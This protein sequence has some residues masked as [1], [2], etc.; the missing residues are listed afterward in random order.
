MKKVLLALLC[1]ILAWNTTL[2]ENDETVGDFVVYLVSGSSCGIKN[3]TGS[4][5]NL[6]IPS[7]IN[8]NER[9]YS[10]AE[11]GEKGMCD[12][13]IESITMP[14]VIDI[15]AESFQNCKNLK[16]VDAPNC[17]TIDN[18]AF[19]NCT[20]LHDLLLPRCTWMKTFA[21][22][23]VCSIP[24][25]VVPN[26]I[27]VDDYVFYQDGWSDKEYFDGDFAFQ[28]KYYFTGYSY[29]IGAEITRY[30]PREERSNI[31]IPNTLTADGGDVYDVINIKSGLFSHSNL[32]K[33]KLPNNLVKIDDELFNGCKNLQ[34]IEIPASVY[35]IGRGAFYECSA[36]SEVVIPE[37]SEWRIGD[38][39]IFRGCSSIKELYLPRK[40]K[41]M[42]GQIITGCNV[43]KLFIP[44]DS[45]MER[46]EGQAI[47]ATT[48]RSIYVPSKVTNL[49]V[50]AMNGAGLRNITFASEINLEEIQDVAIAGNLIATLD[51]PSSVKILGESAIADNQ[52][53]FTLNIPADSK[54]EIIKQKA[55]FN[56]PKLESVTF[57]ATLK[58]IEENALNFIG[59]NETCANS[60]LA[61]LS[62]DVSG[63]S[64]NAFGDRTQQ[65]V[66]AKVPE[67]AV[68]AYRALWPNITYITTDV[69]EIIINNGADA[70]VPVNNEITL[71]A[72]VLPAEALDKVTWSSSD[73]SVAKVDQNGI[74]TGIAEGDV[75]ITATA[76]DGSNV[77]GTCNVHV[78]YVYMTEIH[79]DR[80]TYDLRK[81][82]KYQLKITT[83]PEN[84][85]NRNYTISSSDPAI[86]SVSN[87]NV[88][89]AVKRGT[90]TITALSEDGH[91]TAT[92]TVVV[93]DF[94]AALWT[95]QDENNNGFVSFKDK[96]TGLYMTNGDWAS[97][98]DQP[99]SMKSSEWVIKRADN[100]EVVTSV[101]EGVIYRVSSR[102]S[103]YKMSIDGTG[104]RLIPADWNDWREDVTFVSAGGNDYYI[105]VND[106]LIQQECE[107]YRNLETY[108]GNESDDTWEYELKNL[109]S[110]P[111]LLSVALK[112]YK[113][114]ELSV[115]LPSSLTVGVE[116]YPV[117]TIGRELFSRT[118]ELRRIKKVTIPSSIKYI[119]YHAFADT[120]LQT[121]EIES[122]SQLE[123]IGD[124][125]FW[126]SQITS[127][128][129]PATVRTI[130]TR[131][132]GA[133]RQLQ[134]VTI[135][136]SAPVTSIGD[137]AFWDDNALTTF[138]LP[139]AVKT[140]GRE[141]FVDCDNLQTFILSDN[142]QLEVLGTYALAHNGKFVGINI[143][144]TLKV[145]GDFAFEDCPAAT[146]SN[147]SAGSQLQS[148]GINAF[149]NTKLADFYVPSTV[150]SISS[151]AFNE[152]YALVH[153][154]ADEPVA[155][156]STDLLGENAYAVVAKKNLE[157]Y[158]HADMW[159]AFKSQILSEEDYVQDVTIAAL[160]GESAL[161]NMIGNDNMRNIG[162]LKIS[163]TINGYD[164]M[165]LRNQFVALRHLDLSDAQVVA[166]DNGWQY[167]EG[168]HVED[169]VL[170]A[171]SFSSRLLSVSLPATLD[172]LGNDAFVESRNLTSV[173]FGN[174][175][176]EIGA[177]AFNGCPLEQIELPEGL[178]RIGN[179]AFWG[180]HVKNIQFPATLEYIGRNAFQDNY[181]LQQ[182]SFQGNPSALKVIDGEAFHYC[183]NLQNV[184][185][186]TRLEEIGDWAFSECAF[187]EVKIPSS[188][189]HI[190]DYAFQNCS[191][192]MDVYA[193]VV[194]PIQINQNTFWNWTKAMLHIPEQT[195]EKYHYNTQ[196]NQFINQS[197]FNEDYEYFYLQNNS[198]VTLKEEFT[199][200][201]DVDLNNGSGLVAGE[202]VEQKLGD[203]TIKVDPEQPIASIIGN[204][205]AKNAFVELSVQG[206]RWYFLSFPFPINI[207][208]IE[209]EGQF[210]VRHYNGELRAKGGSGWEALA[211]TEL[212]MGHGYILQ[213]ENTCTIKI[214][215]TNPN[216]FKNSETV[217][218][219]T[220]VAE[221]AQNASW[222][223][224]G[225]PFASYMSI[226]SLGIDVPIT[227]WNG[228]GYE[229]VRPEDDEY[230]L[231]PFE[232][233]F[234]Q[235]PNGKDGVVFA[236]E[237][238]ETYLQTE[239]GRKM[240]KA[241]AVMVNPERLLVNLELTNGEKTDKTRIAFSEKH[242][243]DYEIG[244][245]AAKF[246]A[247]GIPQ[248]YSIEDNVMYSINERPMGD[249]N[250]GFKAPKAGEYSI[251]ASRMDTPMLLKDNLLDVTIDLSNGAYSFSSNEGT[252]GKRFTLVAD[253]SVTSIADLYAQ[254]GISVSANENG[255]SI[256]GASGNTNTFVYTMGGVLVK[257][258][259]GNGLISLKSGGYIVKVNGIAVKTLVK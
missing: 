156:K 180:S 142:S 34:R 96:Y 178:V 201:P 97:L 241:K 212:A 240:A 185:L 116:T 245:D 252:F 25:I 54:L 111:R 88:I 31:E 35:Y 33:V 208:K 118:E 244:E 224:L 165:E 7:T 239:N 258:T 43:D 69:S 189:K 24:N 137:Y 237:F 153:F 234:I 166:N 40:L 22:M 164:V 158:Q 38:W 12:L 51:L 145:I 26:N 250:L 57:P 193:Y 32:E 3:Y 144:S 98:C 225:N 229:T 246:M 195:Q 161:R 232:A 251:S 129:L 196:W 235:K 172:R 13:E 238:S 49:G 30:T 67:S 150:T 50:Q 217:D 192:L 87:D 68:E 151:N 122:G 28:I 179:G 130:G 215:M 138:T 107:M 218:L 80:E 200:T 206:G 92:T 160:P 104:I 4:E 110:A 73:E 16:I 159:S 167:Y 169:N 133:C 14:S 242:T 1:C 36:L 149:K 190:S 187:T 62:T 90:A 170:N 23:N 27:R 75:V 147:E 136:L 58:T 109:A 162:R 173:V 101:E 9:E 125:A 115:S 61:F 171:H 228:S 119:D 254:T 21:F 66:T 186:P 65:Y 226:N 99:E 72:N 121:V 139:D 227:V 123:T 91:T 128:D 141:V 46:F 17:K 176:T 214:P 10:V 64:A 47:H 243:A 42:P 44:E 256:D 2:A 83:V 223:L 191:K 175:I 184:L 210:V 48:L 230:Y 85:S 247:N 45:E 199:G 77:K 221:N 132:L 155:L 220:Y 255:I 103:G 86:V 140:I 114:N 194:D 222:N 127:I 100:G 112:S 8:I 18:W 20:A 113:G 19:D 15:K 216:F 39:G 41:H 257:K 56:T 6:I 163:G 183:R 211:G 78:G 197:T 134:N 11:I 84:A 203:V 182:I 81:G 213:C 157:T 154:L 120:E 117:A 177:N 181:A 205:T 202:D 253:K 76:I 219:K 59:E 29:V 148:I 259:A 249:V 207:N 82:N 63:F 126:N 248:L 52:Q 143:P 233:Y 89:T 71:N 131:A 168:Q 94:G 5:K 74:V 231:K 102:Q 93:N 174:N 53:L 55:L 37:N 95:I 188:V 124:E 60:V 106:M 135:P 152:T 108:L 79:Y 236:A 105:A 204:F 146:F 198:D 209:C 70:T